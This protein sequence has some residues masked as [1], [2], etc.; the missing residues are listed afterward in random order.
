MIDY[1]A[2]QPS[3]VQKQ[4]SERSLETAGVAMSISPPAVQS[5]EVSSMSMKSTTVN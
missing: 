2:L 5:H 4:D 3:P 1:G